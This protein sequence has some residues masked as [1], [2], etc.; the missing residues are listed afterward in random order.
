MIFKLDIYVPI[1]WS[2]NIAPDPSTA[3]FPPLPG[4]LYSAH[5]GRFKGKETLPVDKTGTAGRATL[6][7]AP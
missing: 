1:Y 6:S 5:T 7:V 3:S 4:W 2:A